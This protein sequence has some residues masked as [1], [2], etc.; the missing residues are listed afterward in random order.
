MLNNKCIICPKNHVQ[1]LHRTKEL[2]N[3]DIINIKNY[4]DKLEC[5]ELQKLLCNRIGSPSEDAQVFKCI[6]KNYDIVVKIPNS[7]RK[8]TFMLKGRSEYDISKFLSDN[9]PDYVVI[10]RANALLSSK[11]SKVIE[12]YVK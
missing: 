12:K 3:L 6:I 4:I 2:S 1:G 8:N 9:E 5:E 11:N 7:T 10:T